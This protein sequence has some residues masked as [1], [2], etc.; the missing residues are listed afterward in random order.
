MKQTRYP[1]PG[2][3]NRCRNNY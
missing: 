1:L 2:A 3:D